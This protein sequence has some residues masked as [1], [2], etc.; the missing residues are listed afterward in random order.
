MLLPLLSLLPLL[1]A[2]TVRFP[3]ATAGTIKPGRELYPAEAL[4]AGLERDVPVSLH[5]DP[6]GG[7]R[8]I[9]H[10]GSTLAPLKRASCRLIAD[11]DVFLPRA[12][13]DGRARRTR[14]WFWIW[15]AP[16]TFPENQ[17]A[18]AGRDSRMLP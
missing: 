18:D 11:R 12:T 14:G 9:A 6:A 5:V 17:T 16:E 2:A 7:L 13:A 3:P 1:A 8:C 15:W 4:A 10:G